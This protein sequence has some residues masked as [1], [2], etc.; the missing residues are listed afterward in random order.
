MQVIFISL[1]N[2]TLNPAHC[3]VSMPTRNIAT[4]SLY[5]AESLKK[6]TGHAF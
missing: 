4:F 3:S 2:R 6:L 5:L 1:E